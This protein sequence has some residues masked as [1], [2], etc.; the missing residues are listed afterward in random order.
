MKVSVIVPV[1][2]KAELTRGL[3]ESMRRFDSPLLGEIVI[4][5]NS[6]GDETTRMLDDLGWGKARRAAGSPSY[7]FSQACNFGASQSH[8]GILLFLNNDMIVSDGWIAPLVETVASKGGAAGSKLIN[9]DGTIQQAG[10]RFGAWGL[11]YRVGAGASGGDPRFNRTALEWAMMGA[12]VCVTSE[13]FAKIGGWDE[14]YHFGIE[15]ADI[16][17]KV[18]ESGGRIRNVGSSI[19]THLESATMNENQSALA[20]HSGNIARFNARWGGLVESLTARYI[21]RLRS[22]GVKT[23]SIFG[24][25][26]AAMSLQRKLENG[27]VVVKNMLTFNPP[28][29][30]LLDGVK[31]E[32]ASR[33]VLRGSDRLIIGAQFVTALRD[34]L[35]EN[36]LGDYI[37][38]CDLIAETWRPGEEG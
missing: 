14:G 24:T 37:Y 2:G 8:G 28:P 31:V 13:L 19:I 17:L 29:Q 25:G 9:P 33:E 22:D 32:M 34:R 10:M 5:D 36:G 38:D 12:C 1:K 21:S 16:C 23:V 7:N 4:V 35:A 18:I 15:D 30:P 20:A 27:G 26:S 11:M 6:P 3:L